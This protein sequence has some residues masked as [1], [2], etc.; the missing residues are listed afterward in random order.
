MGIKKQNQQTRAVE[1]WCLLV[2]LGK[3]GHGSALFGLWV[4]A[5]SA[6]RQ[7]VTVPALSQAGRCTRNGQKGS[8]H[9]ASPP[10]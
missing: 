5:G 2:E 7:A 4:L 1:V 8:S 9:P 10:P 6:A 3:A